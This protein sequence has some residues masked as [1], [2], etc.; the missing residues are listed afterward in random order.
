MS[1]D[2]FEDLIEQSDTC[3]KALAD[4]LENSSLLVRISGND[5]R[6]HSSGN[7][8]EFNP[9]SKEIENC[10]KSIE[11]LLYKVMFDFDLI[12]VKVKAEAKYSGMIHADFVH[13]KQKYLLLYTEYINDDARS[14]TF[15][16]C[17]YEINGFL[18]TGP[19]SVWDGVM[20]E[21]NTSALC[22]KLSSCSERYSIVRIF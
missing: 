9:D 12:L 14:V 1:Y 5:F 7:L 18:Y 13:D 8:F 19:E 4:L 17:D 10:A 11:D 3:D 20:G 21:T 2:E 16:G 22:I 15:N 6:A